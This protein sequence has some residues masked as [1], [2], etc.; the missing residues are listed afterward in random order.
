[1]ANNNRRKGHDFERRIA[2]LL[3]DIYPDIQTARYASRE[4]DDNGIDFVNTGYVDIQAKTLKRR[5][6][7]EQVFDAMKTDKCKVFIYKD[8]KHRSPRGEYAVLRLEDL[9]KLLLDFEG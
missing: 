8:N 1:M 3:R 5:P 9:L 4:T 2:K 7:L 6:N